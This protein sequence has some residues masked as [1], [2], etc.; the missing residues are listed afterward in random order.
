[1]LSEKRLRPGVCSRSLRSERADRDRHLGQCTVFICHREQ[2][3]MPP[4]SLNLDEPGPSA[5]YSNDDATLVIHL[6]L[7]AER[8]GTVTGSTLSWVFSAMC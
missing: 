4:V 7:C 3:A 8:Q 5:I 6:N 2:L 1:M